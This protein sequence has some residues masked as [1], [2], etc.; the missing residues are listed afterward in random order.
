MNILIVC[1]G[2]T[3]RSA[4]AEGF[5]KHVFKEKNMTI[6]SAGTGA[7][8]GIKAS[9]KAIEIMKDNGIDISQHRSSF[10]NDEKVET[11]DIIVVMETIHKEYLL[12]KYPEIKDKLFLFRVFAKD[13]SSEIPDPCGQD[14]EIYE[15]IFEIIKR[16]TEGFKKWMEQ[17]QLL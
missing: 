1:T 13:G 12:K 14:K 16:S 5:L 17:R 9:E 8:N 15:K 2:N 4:M 10:V 7:V 6:V 3:C 11:A